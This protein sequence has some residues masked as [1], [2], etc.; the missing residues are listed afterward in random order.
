LLS[1]RRWPVHWFVLL[2]GRWL[3]CWF[4]LLSARWL[5]FRFFLLSGR[6]LIYWIFLLCG[7]TLVH[8]FCLIGSLIIPGLKTIVHGFKNGECS[9]CSQGDKHL[10]EEMFEKH[11]R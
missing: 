10:E 2:S 5:I 7:R 6:W 11:D 1:C 8:W 9:D 4:V 3:V